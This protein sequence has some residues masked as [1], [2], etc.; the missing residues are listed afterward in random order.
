MLVVLVVTVTDLWVAVTCHGSGW[1]R[2][3]DSNWTWWCQKM[4][5]KR[6]ATPRRT[7]A[8]EKCRCRSQDAGVSEASRAVQ[9]CGEG[10]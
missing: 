6:D 3:D 7:C 5:M 10:S 1:Q 2:L 8:M 9:R 4:T